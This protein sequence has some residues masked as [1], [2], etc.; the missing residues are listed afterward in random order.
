MTYF[1]SVFKT[2]TLLRGNHAT[3]VKHY[4]RALDHYL[5]AL[6]YVDTDR[7]RQRLR[8]LISKRF[9]VLVL[10]ILL[11]EDVLQRAEDSKQEAR[12]V[13]ET[14]RQQLPVSDFDTIREQW[15]DTPQVNAALIVAEAAQ[16][17]ERQV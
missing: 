10:Q 17:L 11:A 14:P 2:K 1:N 8:A 5:A 7:E 16:E 4:T 13:A 12:P 15:A 3:A 9:S 6:Q